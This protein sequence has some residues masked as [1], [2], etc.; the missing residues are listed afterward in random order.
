MDIGTAKLP[1]A[2]RR[3]IPHHLLDILTSA[4]RSPWPSSS[5]G[6]ARCWPTSVAVARCRSWSADRRSTPGRSWT[7]SSSPGPTRRSATGSRP[8]STR[9]GPGA[10]HRGWRAGPEA[11][12]RIL[13]ENGRRVVRALE[14]IE[15]TGRPFSASLPRARVPRPASVQ[16]GVDIDRPTLDARI[17]LRVDRMFE[18]GF[19]DEVRGCWTRDWGRAAP[20]A[21]RSA[22]ARSRRTSPVTSRSTRPASRR[23][24]PPGGSPAAR[25]PGSARIRAS[26]G[27]GT[28]TPTAS[29]GRWPRCC[30]TA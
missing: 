26:P 12:E 10:L 29:S 8:S 19:V 6:P 18:A 22:T 14:V 20:P 27:C 4:S 1:V 9:S 13:P 17:Q 7:G 2:E 5:S 11:A 3:G 21:G 25:T 30:V 24:P 15:I 28:T 16:V 23:R